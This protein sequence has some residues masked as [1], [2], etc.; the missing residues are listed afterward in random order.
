ME[1]E[2]GLAAANL[3]PRELAPFGRRVCEM[4][5]NEEAG[6]YRLVEAADPSG[7]Q[8]LAGQFY[9]L[10]AEASWGEDAGRP[11][12]PRAFSVC[13]VRGRRLGFLIDPI[14]PGTA[15]LAA[16]E[17]EEALWVMGP[18]GLG[19]PAPETVSPLGSAAR[20]L[21]VGGGIGIAPLVIWAEAL[22]S[23]GAEP[24]SLLGF[25]SAAYAEAARLLPARTLLASDDGSVGREGVV[26][27]LLEDELERDAEVVVYACGPP[28]MLEAVRRICMKRAVPA[29]LALESAMACGFGACF[30]CVVR[31]TSGY[32]RLC[33][34]GPVVA[35]AELTEPWE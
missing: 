22:V 28:A 26:T 33:V 10:A 14:G 20:P 18:L 35:A 13:R 24:L 4:A 32:R 29:Q 23:A 21:L 16:L 7:P 15:R 19:F 11:Y 8:P 6:L 5:V 30:G 1:V 27:E 34:D 2:V 31:T 17:P 3:G 25:R 9:M 12:L